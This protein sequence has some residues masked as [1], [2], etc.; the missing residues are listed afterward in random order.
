M[1][2]F[3]K[4]TETDKPTI[5]QST[6]TEFH[7][8]GITDTEIIIFT[9]RYTDW[10]LSRKLMVDDAMVGF[11]LLQEDSVANLLDDRYDQCRLLEDLSGYA[12]KRGV[13]GIILL[14]LPQYRGH[15]YGN[16]LKDLPRQMGFDYVYGEQFKASPAVLQHW[17]KRRRLVADC[18]G[19]YGDVWLT[20]EDFTRD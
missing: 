3:A 18:S 13:E 4:I 2:S 7:G 8:N 14:V 5:I 6:V 20:L 15:G 12:N 16:L 1:L 11:Y 19:P 9:N 10:N 17:L